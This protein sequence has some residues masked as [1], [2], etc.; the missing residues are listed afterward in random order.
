MQLFFF[1]YFSLAEYNHDSLFIVYIYVC[2]LHIFTYK[3]Y[4]M[5]KLFPQFHEY[6]HHEHVHKTGL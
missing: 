4:C 3:L 5:D 1:L 6:Y 2:N